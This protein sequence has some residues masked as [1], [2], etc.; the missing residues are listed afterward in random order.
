MEK[1]KDRPRL[2]YEKLNL[3]GQTIFEAKIDQ[4]NP[5]VLHMNIPPLGL[6]PYNISTVFDSERPVLP[7]IKEELSNW[8]PNPEKSRIILDAQAKVLKA[9]SSMRFF[10]L[11][12]DAMRIPSLPGQ[13]VLGDRGEN[14]ST[15][16]QSIVEDSR[17]RQALMEWIKELTPMDAA[18]FEFPIYADGKTLLTLVEKNGQKTSAYSASDGTL[19]FLAFMAALLGPKPSDFYFFEELEN[20]IH[21]TRLRLLIEMIEREVASRY[22]QVIATTHSPQL[23]RIISPASLEAASLVYRLTDQPSAQIQR[24]FGLPEGA[25]KVLQQKDVARLYEFGWFE[26][27]MSFL[28]KDAKS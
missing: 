2:V 4:Q 16:L 13:T 3:G 26:N 27:T 23:L 22:F 28:K 1:F 11:E 7:L 12:T 5:L 20:G 6:G 25:R 14:L 8:N 21:P 9:I 17:R 18:E 15:V 24:I 19:R 10:D